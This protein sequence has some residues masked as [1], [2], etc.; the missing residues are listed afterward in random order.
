MFGEW[1]TI[2]YK[3]PEIGLNDQIPRNIHGNINIF[4][5]NMIPINCSWLKNP[6]SKNIAQDLNIDFVEGCTGFKF[7]KGKATPKIQGI[8]VRNSD[9]TKI[10]E[11]LI[12]YQN[13]QEK[14]FDKNIEKIAC[15][16]WKIIFQIIT[17]QKGIN[18]TKNSFNFCILES[19]ESKK[20]DFEDFEEL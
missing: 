4:T 1:Q 20:I 10:E 3:P 14:V 8:V 18:E 17:N 6:L 9:Y 7:I 15:K 12:F 5:E 11:N 2:F 16:K 19:K 13:I